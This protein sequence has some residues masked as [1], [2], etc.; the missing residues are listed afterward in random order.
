MLGY[1]HFDIRRGLRADLLNASLQALLKDH[2]M[3]RE[4]LDA[5]GLNSVSFSFD[6][7]SLSGAKGKKL[8]LIVDGKYPL[9][10]HRADVLD[11]TEQLWPLSHNS[12]TIEAIKNT[13]LAK[14][15]SPS[16]LA[17]SLR[18]LDELDVSQACEMS[19]NDAL[20]I[21]CQIVML[22]SF[23][24]SLDPKFVSA[25]KIAIGDG[26]STSKTI[27]R[28][29]RWINE[30]AI[31]TPVYHV[32]EEIDVDVV[33]LAFIKALSTRYGARG[34]SIIRKIGYGIAPGLVATKPLM[35]EALWCEPYL[36][37]TIN[38]TGLANSARV[39]S[40][41]QIYGSVP[42]SYDMAQL[43]LQLSLHGAS[44]IHWY[45]THG[46]KNLSCYFMRFLVN[47]DDKRDAIEAFLVK[48]GA[49]DVVVSSV[50][51][52]QLNRRLVSLPLGHGHKAFSARFYEYIYLDNTVRVEPVK[53][54]LEMYM[55][56]T[57][58][59]AE[60]ARS[61]MLLAWK[62]WRGRV[63]AEDA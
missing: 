57:N 20:W 14:P 10:L 5:F 9:E 23:I 26:A 15:L 54:D 35:V 63:V 46:E 50:E 1:L 62:K 55:Q 24:E 41:Y 56:K 52:H 8:S 19:R 13:F 11:V 48:G 31:D 53:D 47:D 18:V 30:I 2:C 21:V 28:E 27:V 34:E 33:G 38:D 45:L 12:I 37:T 32:D 6:E 40:L 51:R 29:H 61:D 59:S 25:T 17:L 43:S 60:V 7:M 49:Y 3:V 36:P 42:A 44:S 39:V 58:Y 16:M 22:V 4:N